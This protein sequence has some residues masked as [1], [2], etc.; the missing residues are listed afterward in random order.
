MFHCRPPLACMRY[1]QP[2][3]DKEP[4]KWVSVSEVCIQRNVTQSHKAT[5]KTRVDVNGFAASFV[6]SCLR[7]RIWCECF[8][9]RGCLRFG[10]QGGCLPLPPLVRTNSARPFFTSTKR[11]RVTQAEQLRLCAFARKIKTRSVS[12]G[13]SRPAFRGPFA[14]KC[15]VRSVQA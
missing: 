1:W 13:N 5:K 2:W 11:E 12:E 15:N 7:V 8:P 6:A 10:A 3:A 4:T 9:K 14:T